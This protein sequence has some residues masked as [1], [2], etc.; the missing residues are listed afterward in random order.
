MNSRHCLRLQNGW[1]Q[2]NE[3]DNEGLSPFIR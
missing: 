2:S 1:G 3:L